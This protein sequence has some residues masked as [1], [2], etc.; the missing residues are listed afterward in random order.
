MSVP[1]SETQSSRAE[2]TRRQSFASYATALANYTSSS[3]ASAHH[4][5]STQTPTLQL[6]IAYQGHQPTD[7]DD[8]DDDLYS[9]PTKPPIQKPVAPKRTS[10]TESTSTTKTKSSS[11]SSRLPPDAYNILPD[12]PPPPKRELSWKEITERALVDDPEKNKNLLLPW[13]IENHQS[14]L[15]LPPSPL[16]PSPLPRPKDFDSDPNSTGNA[17]LNPAPAESK[18]GKSNQPRL[19]FPAHPQSPHL[20]HQHSL[21]LYLQKRLR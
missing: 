13:Q 8:D 4:T 14:D 12:H 9:D 16:P 1:T 2:S 3:D 10:S 11:A 18:Q 20:N 15:P 7:V 6:T 17:Q 19:L 5:P 21:L